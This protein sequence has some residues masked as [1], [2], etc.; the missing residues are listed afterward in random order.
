MATYSVDLLRHGDCVDKAIYRGRTDSALSTHGRQQMLRSCT[1]QRWDAVLSSPLQRC[2]RFAHELASE[3]GL[4]LTLDARLRELDFGVWDGQPLA[5]IW[6]A[7]PEAVQAFWRDPDSH[8][9]PGGESFGALS[10]RC[11]SLLT[12]FVAQPVPRLLVVTH[13]GVIR[14]MLAEILRLSPDAVQSLTIDYASVTRLQFYRDD[15]PGAHDDHTP[16]WQVRFINWLP[17]PAGD[18]CT[19]R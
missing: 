11:R 10:E 2:S 18:D 9:P 4:A 14:A 6:A 19:M 17:H 1:G 3:Q 13:G 8:P 16:C 12:T 5:Q 15:D 7:A